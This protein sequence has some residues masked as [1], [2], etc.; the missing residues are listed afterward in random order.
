MK[1]TLELVYSDR[2]RAIL[3]SRVF[4]LH[5]QG[6]YTH[7]HYKEDDGTMA[8]HI[9]SKHLKTFLPQL[10]DRFLEIRRG[11]IINCDK[12]DCYYHNRTI[13]LRMPDSPLVSVPKA[14]WKRVKETLRGRNSSSSDQEVIPSDQ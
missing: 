4:Y 14:Q 12:L 7:V 2:V 6:S 8:C 9:Q 10:D 5:A 3:L 13:K 11:C 1:P